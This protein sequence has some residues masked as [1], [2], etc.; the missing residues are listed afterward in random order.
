MAPLTCIVRTQAA[1][2]SGRNGV[3]T[4]LPSRGGS[5]SRLNHGGLFLLPASAVPSVRPGAACH[6]EPSARLT[7]T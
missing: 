2:A 6:S 4:A 7:S 5:G 1:A 3:I